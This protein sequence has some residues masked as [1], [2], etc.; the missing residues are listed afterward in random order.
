M[1]IMLKFSIRYIF[2]VYSI[3]LNTI[4]Y[5]IWFKLGYF[6]IIRI[7]SVKSIYTTKIHITIIIFKTRSS[8]KLIRLKTIYYG[9]ILKVIFFSAKCRYT[10]ICTYPYFI[11]IINQYAVYSIIYKSIFFCISFKSIFINI[12]NI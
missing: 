5:D 10:F 11:T 7:K 3:Y 8:I 2:S 4:K 9:E 1:F 6:Y 12:K